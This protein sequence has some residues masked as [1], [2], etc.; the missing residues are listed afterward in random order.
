MASLRPL[1]CL[2][3]AT[4]RCGFPQAPD[5]SNEQEEAIQKTSLTANWTRKT[6]NWTRKMS[7]AGTTSGFPPRR[8]RSIVT[9]FSE[10][11]NRQGQS[12]FYQ[13]RLY[14]VV[15]NAG[16]EPPTVQHIKDVQSSV[17]E[18]RLQMTARKLAGFG[19]LFV[20]RVASAGEIAASMHSMKADPS[21][22]RG[23]RL[24]QQPERS[25]HIG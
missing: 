24:E 11:Q 13:Q 7:N 20:G 17:T 5:S 21:S 25:L 18:V 3:R 8:E 23:R 10:A 9:I 15:V 4:A 22:V 2:M 1:H 6:A 12:G 14:G 19:C 16:K